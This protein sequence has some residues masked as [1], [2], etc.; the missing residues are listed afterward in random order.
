MPTYRNRN[1]DQTVTYDKRNERLDSLTDNWERIAEDGDVVV[2]TTAKV[3][4]S[5]TDK[6]GN[7]HPLPDL[8]VPVEGIGHADGTVTLTKPAP[9]KKATPRKRAAKTAAPKQS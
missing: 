2:S 5:A 1:T 7:E 6:D 8:T 9:A 4:V 3:K